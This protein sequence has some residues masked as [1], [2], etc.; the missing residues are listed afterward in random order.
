MCMCVCLGG[1]EGACVCLHIIIAGVY[2]M[3]CTCSI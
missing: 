1:G 3:W 2:E